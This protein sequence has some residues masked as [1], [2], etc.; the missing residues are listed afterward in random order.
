MEKQIKVS[1]LVNITWN[2][3]N[4]NEVMKSTAVPVVAK[5]H[6]DILTTEH[7]RRRAL[8]NW[9]EQQFREDHKEYG[10][11]GLLFGTIEVDLLDNS[12][13]EFNG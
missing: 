13:Y 10:K 9:A 3:R 5:Y 4:K 1:A 2:G 6:T 7:Q 8:M 11:F 12:Y